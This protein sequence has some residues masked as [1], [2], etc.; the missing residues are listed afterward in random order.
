M[1]PGWTSCVLAV[2]VAIDGATA[3]GAS[4]AH[5]GD[6]R[7]QPAVGRRTHPRRTAQARHPSLQADG[8]E[9]HATPASTR[10][11]PAMV[12]VLGQSRHVATDFVQTY[13]ARFREIFVLFF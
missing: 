10:R 11:W 5:P 1:A 8:P 3:N 7:K 12:D 4:L 6:G 13:D 2:P 9:V